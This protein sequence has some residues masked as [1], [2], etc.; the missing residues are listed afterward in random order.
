VLTTSYIAVMAE[1]DQRVVMRDVQ[2]VVDKLP[3]SIELPYVTDVY[4]ATAIVR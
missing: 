2:K 4:R 1:D 3:E